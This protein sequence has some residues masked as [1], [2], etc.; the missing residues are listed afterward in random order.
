MLVDLTSIWL[1]GRCCELAANGL[2]RDSKRD[3]SQIVFGLVCMS[4]GCPLSEE[5]FKGNP[6]DAATLAAQVSKLEERFCIQ[7]IAWTGDRGTLTSAR[8][9]Q[10]LE[11]QGMDWSARCAPQL[12]AEHG[13]SS[14]RCSTSAISWR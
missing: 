1:T 13:R 8:I 6:A 11:P 14:P 5:M 4:K 10:V 9:E 3:D 12:A 2:S 7:R